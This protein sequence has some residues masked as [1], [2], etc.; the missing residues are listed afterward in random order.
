MTPFR[1]LKN[2]AFSDYVNLNAAVG[3]LGSVDNSCILKL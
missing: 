1:L 2:W 3:Q